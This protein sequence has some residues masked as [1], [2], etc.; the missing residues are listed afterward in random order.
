MEMTTA[1]GRIF[2]HVMAAL[3]LM[4]RALTVE[5][6]RA[7][8]EAARKRVMTNR[9]ITDARQLLAQ[10]ISAA[11]IPHN[12]GGSIPTLYRWIPASDRETGKPE[13]RA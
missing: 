9:K 10:G 13:N 5:R 4:E 1:A 11:D 7:G 3:A 12:V 8:L 2:F 6:T